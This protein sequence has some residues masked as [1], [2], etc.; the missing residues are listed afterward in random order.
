MSGHSVL[1]VAPSAYTLSG[2]ATWL[3]YLV[4]GLRER[5][6]DARLG[7]VAGARHHDPERYLAMH[8]VASAQIIRCDTG[9]PEG[10]QRAIGRALEG[11]QPDM[12]VSVNIPDLFPAIARRRA[13]GAPA[14]RALLSVHGIEA[15]L[16]ADAARYRD[17]LDAMICTNRL[18]CTLGEQLGGIEAARIHYASYGVE[19]ADAANSRQPGGPLRLLYSGRLERE[20]KRVPDLVGIVQALQERGV[21]F[22]LE[23]AGDGPERESLQAALSHEREVGRVRFL[24]HLATEALHA[25]YETADILI[26][27]SLWETGPIV[28]WE[29]MARGAVVVSSRYIGS[30]LEGALVDGANC[31]LFEIGDADGA[32]ACI[33]DLAAD[34]GLAVRLRQGARDLLKSR[35]T[36][37]TSV[38]HWDEVLRRA[39]AADPIPAVSGHRPQVLSGSGRLDRWLGAGLAE[40]VRSLSGRRAPLAGDAGGEWPHAH[41]RA[42]SDASFWRMAQAVDRRDTAGLADAH[43][44]TGSLA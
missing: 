3:D 37:A 27:T 43:H 7:L 8:P 31:R 14:P 10:R 29:A 12:A 26:I 35:Y 44:M 13:L 41:A 17:L 28:A 33:A 2:L 38:A 36:V 18:A 5:G 1:F 23:I 30:G 11:L 6:W 39:L 40:S 4:P 25:S 24:G 19:L 42:R 21:E 22:E 34:P 16:Y 9:T 32:S 20:Q 15:Y